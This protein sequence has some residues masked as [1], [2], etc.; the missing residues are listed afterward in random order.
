MKLELYIPH[1][2]TNKLPE[3]FNSKDYLVGEEKIDGSRYIFYIGGDPYERSFPNALL[4][5][6]ISTHDSKYVDRTQNC[7][8]FTTQEYTGLK[9]TV[10]DGEV[11]SI[12]FLSTNSIMNSS[13][14][15]A[16]E[17]QKDIGF[18]TY[19][20]FD[21]MMFRGKSIA[22]LPLEQR[23]KILIEAVNQMANPYIRVVEQ[24]TGD[25]TAFFNYVVTKGGE[26]IIIKDTRKAYGDGWYK[27]KK[28][29]DVSCIISGW[30]PGKGKYS[31]MIG[32]LL[33]SVWHDGKL[34]EIGRAS[35]FNDDLRIEMTK[36]FEKFKGKV[37]D[38]FAQEIQDSKRSVGNPVGR[39]RHPTFYRLRDDI[40]AE[41]CTSTKLLSDMKAAKNSRLKT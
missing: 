36:N 4:S 31:G 13:P 18:V 29:Y 28:S 12:N 24:V 2:C 41:D 14:I 37:I 25:L 26:G 34:V 6:R 20:V 11:V 9:G 30:H 16:I 10:L 19:N 1:R 38:V 39:L 27:M 40:N 15:V 33:L 23:R 5:R 22:H 7:P 8:H 3:N 32:A 35:G 21:I 17:K